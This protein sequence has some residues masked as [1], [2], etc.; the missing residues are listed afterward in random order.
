M[1]ATDTLTRF[2]QAIDRQDWDA[3]G[4]LLAPDFTGRYVH[5]AE[6]FDRDA[7][8]A[9]NRDYPGAWRF[10]YEDIVADGDR[11]VGRARIWDERETYHV[12]TFVTVT[13]GLIT[14]LVEVWTDAVTQP[15][16]TRR[17]R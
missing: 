13:G 14:E 17:P 2:G 6:T 15:D 10:V 12:A 9:L 5:T 1:S 3:M 4:A 11:A 16:P 7:L 8:V